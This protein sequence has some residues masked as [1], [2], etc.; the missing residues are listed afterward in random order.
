MSLQTP[1]LRGRRFALW[2]LKPHD[3]H[4]HGMQVSRMSVHYA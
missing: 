2:L 4:A 3:H 1:F